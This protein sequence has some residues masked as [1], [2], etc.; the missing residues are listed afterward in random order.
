MDN[1]LFTFS[2]QVEQQNKA[3][4][5]ISLE[6]KQVNTFKIFDFWKDKAITK[7]GKIVIDSPEYRDISIPVVEDWGEPSCWCCNK[8]VNV[9]KMRGYET[10]LSLKNFK[11]IWNYSKVSEY[12]QKAHIIPFARGG[13]NEPY[14]FFLLCQRCHE[15][16]P[17]FMIAKYFYKYIYK[18]RKNGWSW[19]NYFSSINIIPNNLQTITELIEFI[20]NNYSI[21][22]ENLNK[23][24]T[25]EKLSNAL[26][27]LCNTHGTKT[28]S[29][30]IEAA[31]EY[32]IEKYAIEDKL[33]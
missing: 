8:P 18:A 17:D 13:S 4:D 14:N 22:Y 16:T 21:S 6:R 24:I 7:D 12:L 19:P 31:I 20:H 26:I 25:K 9:Y 30:T 27:S 33:G 11:A 29:S 2:E 1:S 32:I 5:N 10:A 3:T 28:S 15:N 23:F